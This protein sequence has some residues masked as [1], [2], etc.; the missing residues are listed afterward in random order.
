VTYAVPGALTLLNY[1]GPDSAT[2]LAR[3]LVATKL[4]QASGY[5]SPGLAALVSSADGF[6]AT[7]PPGSNPRGSARNTANALKDALE[8]HYQGECPDPPS[9]CSPSPLGMA[10]GWNVFVRGTL[11]QNYSDTEGKMAAGGDVQLNGYSVGLLE[12]PS[13]GTPVL[14]AGGHLL[15]VNGTASGGDIVYKLSA[16]TASL[17]VPHGVIR[18]GTVIDF[19]AAGVEL[20][21]LSAGLAA[22]P[23]NG[24]VTIPPWNAISLDGTHAER[25]VFHLTTAELQATSSVTIRVPAGSTV[26]VNVSGTAPVMQYFGFTLDGAT[27]ERIVWNFPQATSLTMQGVGVQGS[28]LAPRAAVQFNNGVIHGSLVASS[29]QGNGQSNRVSFTGC[30]PSP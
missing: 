11:A 26:V 8:A 21:G 22:L 23:Q 7:Y 2:K 15:F 29:L 3:A 27:A 25:N 19:A 16:Q 18:Q 6:L 4:N 13:P 17:S 24:T 5:D 12:P 1:G 9:A 10:T 28:V 14:V 30:L 20:E